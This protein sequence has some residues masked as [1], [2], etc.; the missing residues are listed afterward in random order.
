MR[1]LNIEDT[2][3]KHNDIRKVLE[4]CRITKVDCAR[5]LADGIAMY[6]DAVSTDK[7]YDLIITD[8]WYPPDQGMDEDRCGDK[9]VSIAIEEKWDV[10]VIVCSNQNYSYPG[11]LGCLYY[12]E[13]EDWEGELR[14]Y[15]DK[16]RKMK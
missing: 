10:E 6:K 11:I 1:V 14:K 7:P 16:M 13:N 8:M 4:D 2:P 12:S 15:I 9:L 5:T 3:I